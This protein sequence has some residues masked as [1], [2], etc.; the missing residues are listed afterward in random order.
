[1]YTQVNHYVTK[2][3]LVGQELGLS[4]IRFIVVDDEGHASFQ[5]ALMSV[6]SNFINTTYAILSISV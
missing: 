1:M 4:V 5:G 6:S 3:L 2:A